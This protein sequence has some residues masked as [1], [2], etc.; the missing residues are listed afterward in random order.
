MDFEN[1][2]LSELKKVARDHGV[3]GYSTFTKTTRNRLIELIQEQLEKEQN[4][5]SAE[6]E[7]TK[8]EPEG[9]QG[10]AKPKKRTTKKKEEPVETEEHEGAQGGAKPKPKKRTTKKKEPE[11]PQGETE[12]TC[13]I[14]V[15][16]FTKSRA[17]VICSHCRDVVCSKCFSTQ[18]LASEAQ[19]CMLCNANISDEFVSM[20][21]TKAFRSKFK[22]KKA[23]EAYL[24]QRN[25]LPETQERLTRRMSI[26]RLNFHLKE[27]K[28]MKENLKYFR[29][30]LNQEDVR[31]AE[32]AIERL[33]QKVAEIERE[34][35]E[36][37]Y[38]NVFEPIRRGGDEED[39]EEVTK[40]KNWSRPCP[41]DNCRG[42][43]FSGSK[44][45]LC[46]MLSC[47]KCHEP[48][49]D[50]ENHECDKEILKNVAALKKET[51][52]C[53]S[54]HIPIFKIDGCDQMWCVECKTFFSWKTGQPLKHGSVR[55][56]PHY[57]EW[58]RKSGNDIPRQPGDVVGGGECR[59]PFIP[60]LIYVITDEYIWFN[61]TFEEAREWVGNFNGYHYEHK[62]E[63]MEEQSRVKF[64]K[65]E[66]DEQGWKRRVQVTKTKHDRNEGVA[67]ILE[68][69]MQSVSDL[70]VQAKNKDDST[71]SKSE[72]KCIIKEE[73][74]QDRLRLVEFINGQ[75]ADLKERLGSTAIMTLNEERFILPG[76]GV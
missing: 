69:F 14:C 30:E 9:A 45:D 62:L 75:F 24:I 2:T 16:P 5:P 36:A 15:E 17:K 53:P 64:L 47:K 4:P 39:E 74:E 23:D 8:E 63:E 19:L 66:M 68:M 33:E 48:M 22:H 73:L 13:V 43:I 70:L 18:I 32:A 3:R 76:L 11:G 57:F 26:M 27:L 72:E 25:R 7:S 37:G 35:E 61:R 6:V 54:C 34:N 58:L 12:E 60:R 52:A 51:R 21:T 56:N 42:F 28:N 20:H 40:K 41:H 44:C 59:A 10:G 46:G 65:N 71:T 38:N 1:R 50:K 31:N 29:R 67:S 55:H 49:E